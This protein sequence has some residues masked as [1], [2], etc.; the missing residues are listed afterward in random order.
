MIAFNHPLTLAAGVLFLLGF[1]VLGVFG[2]VT[3]ERLAG[4]P[5]QPERDL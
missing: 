4:E 5:E 1:V 2:L 3:P